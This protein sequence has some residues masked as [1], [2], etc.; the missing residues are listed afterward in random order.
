MKH[1]VEVIIT[2]V[3]IIVAARHKHHQDSPRAEE[4]EEEEEVELQVDLPEVPPA[5][6]VILEVQIAIRA[7][8]VHEQS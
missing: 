8:I 5:H 7:A 3:I 4:D 2:V 1:V 6:T